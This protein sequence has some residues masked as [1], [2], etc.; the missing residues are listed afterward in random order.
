MATTQISAIWT[1]QVA[2]SY[3]VLDA[4]EKTAFADSGIL[5][6]TDEMSTL[7]NSRTP[8]IEMPY[9]NDLDAS[10]EPNYSTDNPA[11][12][13][14]PQAVTTGMMSAYVANLNEGFSSASL[15]KE[16][17]AKDPLAELVRGRINPYWQRQ[18]QRRLIATAIGVYRENVAN[19]SSDMVETDTATGLNADIII[20]AEA[21]M[22]DNLD[23]LGAIVMHSKKYADLQKQNLIDFVEYSDAKTRFAMY[24]NKRVVVDD[25]MPN[26]GTEL[27]PQYLTIVFGAGAIGYAV[28]Q[29]YNAETIA[30]VDD[31][32]NGGGVETLWTRRKFIIHPLGYTFTADTITGNGTEVEALAPSWADLALA[33]NWER[34][35]PRKAVP[36]SFIVSG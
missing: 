21:S 12:I 34:I 14:V 25:S 5:T 11:D 6:T 24:Q 31:Q 2:S 30:Y 29:P 10:I 26:L 17:T 23:K 16:L 4:L 32:A 8:K 20:D 36:I 35:V 19:G 13:A 33:V 9:W 1:P 15:V 18:A 3:K 22:G 7:L 28:G 27:A